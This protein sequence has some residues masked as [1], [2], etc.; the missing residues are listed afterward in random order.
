MTSYCCSE[1]SAPTIWSTLHWAIKDAITSNTSKERRRNA[2]SLFPVR[3]HV[4]LSLILSE[5]SKHLWEEINQSHHDPL[6]RLTFGEDGQFWGAMAVPD[7]AG[8]PQR[9]FSNTSGAFDGNFRG[10]TKTIL[11]FDA[12]KFVSLGNGTDWAYNV[13]GTTLYCGSPSFRKAIRTAKAQNN[14]VSVSRMNYLSF[15]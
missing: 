13:D 10:H 12:V 3:F 1:L 14:E 6:D 11:S 8:H 5:L 15:L 2:V 7:D 4:A 9:L